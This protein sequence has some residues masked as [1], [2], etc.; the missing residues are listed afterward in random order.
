MSKYDDESILCKDFGPK[1]SLGLSLTY[2]LLGWLVATFVFYDGVF[3]QRLQV[4]LMG[5][6]PMLV[7]DLPFLGSIVLVGIGLSLALFIGLALKSGSVDRVAL[8]ALAFSFC[9]DAVP[10]VFQISLLSIFII[11]VSRGLKYQRIPFRLTP[12]IVFIGFILISYMVSFLQTDKPLSVLSNLFYRST[13]FVAMLL[14]PGILVSRRHLETL[15]DFMLLAAMLTVGVEIA[16]FILSAATEQII[17]FYSDNY[18]RVVT[19]FGVFPRL[20]GLMY[21]PNHQS[22]ILA[23]QAIM[24]LWFAT[25]PKERLKHGRRVFLLIAYVVLAFG[26]VITWSRSGWLS[27]AIVTALVP[28]LRYKKFAPWYLLLMISLLVIAYTTGFASYAYTLVHDLNGSSADFR[29]HVDDIAIEAFLSH[30]WFGV[31]VGMFTDFFNP[32]QLE[33]HDTYLQVASGMGI[34]GIL[35]VGG[36]VLA[37]VLRLLHTCFRPRDIVYREWAIALLLGLLIT[38]IQAMFAMFLWVKFLWAMFGISE[39]VVL[40]NRAPNGHEPANDFIFLPP[41][42]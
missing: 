26:V 25:Q 35:T 18:N 2:V 33:V 31:G 5:P 23:T 9:S 12:M 13:Y 17:T 41:P 36:F 4:E 16:Q 30:P 38:S 22:N 34:V 32:Y 28:L 6:N 40:N 11:L 42:R 20:T 21:H 14:L 1:A 37:I 29:W 24:A 3:G 27:I 8:G 19:P 39:A 10:W 7:N 15:F